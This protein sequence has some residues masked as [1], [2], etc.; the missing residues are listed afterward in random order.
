MQPQ[1][2]DDMS[3]SY[4]DDDDYNDD[5]YGY[6][7]DSDDNDDDCMDLEEKTESVIEKT[8][9][10]LPESE[11]RNRQEE[12]IS[13]VS[14]TLFISHAAASRLLYYY[15]WDVSRLLDN[16]F[17]DES[18]VRSEAGLP[19]IET[20][21]PNTKEETLC[22]ICFE[23]FPLDDFHFYP[24]D[25]GHYY[26]ATCLNSY[27]TISIQDGPGC[28][29][30]KCPEPK[31]TASVCRD[32]VDKLVGPDEKKKYD[33]F[34]LR[35]FI[36]ENK[37][38]KWC[39]APGCQ[40]AV[41][42]DSVNDVYD[43]KCLCEHAFCWNCVEEVHRPAD[44]ETVSKWILKNSSESENTAWILANSKPCPKCSRAIEKNN[45]C[46]H[47]TCTPPC[48]FEFCWLCLGDWKKHGETTGGYYACNRYSEEKAKGKYDEEETKRRLAK[49]H[50]E[51]YTHYYERWAGNQKSREKAVS[52][53]R[54]LKT[55]KFEKLSKILDKPETQF[56]FILTAWEQIIE[57][58]QV[59]KWTYAYGYYIPADQHRKK[60]LFEYI[61][62]EAEANLEGLH[63][64]AEKELSDFLPEENRR[65]FGILNNYAEPEK[66][67]TET[68]EEILKKEMERLEQFT[69]FQ[70]KLTTLTKVTGS[71]F[72]KLVR[73]LEK[74]LS[75]FDMMENESGENTASSGLSRFDEAFDDLNK[76]EY[77][78]CDGCTFANPNTSDECEMC[79]L[80]QPFR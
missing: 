49:H 73:D 24:S 79:S 66:K 51:K 30:L 8:Y 9:T 21:F 11:I 16:W 53:M 77:W 12:G 20:V 10:V 15:K 58:R 46:M 75:E 80:G 40:N 56:E 47:M 6:D 25:C 68:E 64:C 17:A 44:C 2:D 65:D 32:M 70:Y 22:G 31:C 71:H 34:F 52:D 19:T 23:F 38:S 1:D 28:L 74:G 62:G 63:Q 26:C 33:Q 39:P 45:G 61:Q 76:S 57:C 27:V 5:D 78:I 54:E 60:A 59:L 18:K 43:V 48:K 72:E 42:F 69:K 3:N 41:E 36:E 55:V 4:E 14:S 13:H 35:S 7:Y 67:E 29:S 37:K 50:V